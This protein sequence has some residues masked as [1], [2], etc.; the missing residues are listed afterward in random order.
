MELFKLF[1][2]LK[3]NKAWRESSLTML[4]YESLQIIG[5]KLM[6]QKGWSE[7]KVEQIN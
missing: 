1:Y 3:G 4:N 2:K 5:I 7:I 6:L